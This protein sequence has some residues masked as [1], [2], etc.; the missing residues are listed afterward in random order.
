MTH[1]F[2]TYPL[3][4]PLGRLVGLVT[5]NRVRA[6]PP[7]QR[8]T[9]RLWDIACP[10]AEVPIARPEDSVHDLLE[11]MH[12]CADGRAVVVDDDG[13]VMGVVSPT[14]VARALDWPTSGASI[15]IQHPPAPMSRRCRGTTDLRECWGRRFAGP[16]ANGDTAHTRPWLAGPGA[17]E[18]ANSFRWFVRRR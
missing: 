6:V 2:S 13:R 16:D 8:S 11:R 4:D 15:P 1:R 17:R 12:G 5:L 14:D 7:A 3:V 18:A 9:T 10:P